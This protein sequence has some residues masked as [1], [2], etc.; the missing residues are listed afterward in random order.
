MLYFK[1]IVIEYLFRNQIEVY[2]SLKIN[3]KFVLKITFNIT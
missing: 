1:Y 2:A 3:F